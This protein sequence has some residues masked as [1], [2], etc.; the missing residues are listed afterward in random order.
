V[1]GEVAACSTVRANGSW[2]ATP[3]IVD[4]APRDIVARSMVLEVLEGRGAGPNK[5]YV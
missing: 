3:H 2:S 4:L 5:D 1:R